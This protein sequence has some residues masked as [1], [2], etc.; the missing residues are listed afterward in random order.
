[1]LYLDTLLELHGVTL[2][3]DYN[4]PSLFYYMPRSPR[5]TREAGQPMFQLLI[6]RSM[7]RD[8]ED[9]SA[10]ERDGGGFLT[11][12]VDLHVSSTTLQTIRDELEDRIGG[13]VDLA[14]VPFERGS[15]RVTA[16]GAAA[17]GTPAL[18]G[19]VGE[20]ESGDETRSPSGFVEQILGSARPSLYGDN[21][22]VFSVEL[23]RRGAQLMEA[24]L[25]AGG[26][27]Q[28]AVVYEL[29]YRGLMPARECR[30]TIDFRQCY[31]HMRTR[32]TANSLWFKSDIDAETE[33]LI[34]EGAIEIEDVDYLG[35]EDAA[36]LATRAD[37]LKQFAQDLASWSFFSPGLQPGQVLAVERGQLQVY[38]PPT[39]LL[40]QFLDS[41]RVAATGEGAS[42]D[43]PGPT[44]AGESGLETL[45]RVGGEPLPEAEEGDGSSGT[46][47][48][49][50]GEAGEGDGELSAIERWDRAGRPQAG[51]ML[52]SLS[53]EE[54]QRI[55][56]D[57][58]Q[59]SAIQR[60]A[61]PQ[62]SIRLATGDADLAGR[63][64]HVDLGGTFFEVLAGRVT[65][66][67]DLAE[68]G[69]RS[70]VVKLRYGQ[71]EDGGF[72][73]DTAEVLLRQ[74][75]DAGDFAFFL[76]HRLSVELEYQV[77]AHYA[78]GFA[79]GERVGKATTEWIRTTTRNLDIDPGQLGMV[80][81][82]TLA[83]GQV[84]WDQ[85]QRVQTKVTYVDAE[86]GLSGESTH[87]LTRDEPSAVV[88]VRPPEG[89]SRRFEVSST[90][91]YN[92][93]REGPIN[94]AG[95]GRA[96][97]VLNQPPSRAV[98]VNASL[99]DPLGRI[100]KVTL[101]LVYLPPEGGGEQSEMIELVGEGASA[102]WTLHR[103]ADDDRP[104][105]RYRQT[106]FR[107]DG[108]VQQTE[109][110][111]T[112]ERQ[113]I[114]GDRVAGML[115]VQVRWMVPDMAAAGY[116]LARLRLSYP[117][118]PEWADPDVETIFEGGMAEPFR[119]RVPRSPGGGREYE[120]TVTWYRVDGQ[121]TVVGPQRANDEVLILLS[122]PAREG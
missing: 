63:I 92:D 72:P 90:Y 45:E 114:V 53:Q 59:V 103:A 81:P 76:D 109:W 44:H 67:A 41:R 47:D 87:V 84:D 51:F 116:V 94:Q 104:R 115:D 89:G 49:G 62:N 16:L 85:V 105:Y 113:L 106:V 120:Y 15:V 29:D 82:V 77:E 9:V 4:T 83:T 73:K 93:A 32:A 111:E 60:T 61:A 95:T 101:E 27:S 23:T 52:R 86:S 34:K 55:T 33:K 98:A 78:S 107:I 17:G 58:R 69:V 48:A 20:G 112:G 19:A 6:Y 108:T 57:L 43:D 100:S 46:G 65:T 30:I 39:E 40:N 12:T 56:F 91:F 28:I 24:S 26:A 36:A 68:A 110:V 13:A 74:T 70:M 2:F 3:R 11:M 31:E 5:L 54:Q 75:G 38:E 42:A 37:Q 64:Q 8:G 119:W 50:G 18:E 79:I 118:A 14:P 10:L 35:S 21:R 22:A 71:R 102:T 7:G 66:T 1:M 122:P 88:H 25:T 99:V 97:I 121:Q 80:F 117:D 96:V